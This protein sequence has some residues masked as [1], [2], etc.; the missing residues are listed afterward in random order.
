MNK[1]KNRYLCGKFF[2]L[3]GEGGALSRINR[4]GGEKNYTCFSQTGN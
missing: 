3:R 4:K 1:F 2:F